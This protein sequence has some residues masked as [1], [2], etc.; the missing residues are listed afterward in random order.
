MKLE[1]SGP[2]LTI[3][4]HELKCRLLLGGL[5][6]PSPRVIKDTVKK[7]AVVSVS[8]MIKTRAD[9]LNN[10]AYSSSGTGRS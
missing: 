9:K 1:L 5:N 6:N 3:N 7:Y 4:L 10:I 8:I 2:F